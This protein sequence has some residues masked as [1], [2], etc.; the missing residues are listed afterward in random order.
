MSTKKIDKT[1]LLNWFNSSTPSLT[2]EESLA[3]KDFVLRHGVDFCISIL[4]LFYINDKSTFSAQNVASRISLVYA[5]GNKNSLDILY[6]NVKSLH[7]FEDLK[8]EFLL[9]LSTK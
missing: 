8:N 6:K 9:F 7:S 2:K 5:N 1:F 4:V 3:V